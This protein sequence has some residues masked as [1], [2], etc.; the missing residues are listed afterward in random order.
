M[1]SVEDEWVECEKCSKWRRLPNHISADS[2]PDVWE[3]SMT[4]WN[5][6]YSSCTA[7]EEVVKTLED[8]SAL[9]T[10][11]AGTTLKGSARHGGDGPHADGRHH[12]H[13][14][15]DD[16]PAAISTDG[17]RRKDTGSSDDLKKLGLLSKGD[18]REHGLGKGH[19]R[20]HLESDDEKDDAASGVKFDKRKKGR[21]GRGSGVS[22][23]QWVQCDNASCGK[24]R[25]LPPNLKLSD[26]PS[27]WYCKNNTNREFAACTA[28]LEPDHNDRS[29]GDGSSNATGAEAGNKQ[30][31]QGIVER[32][33]KH[34]SH[35]KG[36]NTAGAGSGLSRSGASSDDLKKQSEKMPIGGRP[37]QDPASGAKRGKKKAT[38]SWVQCE[39]CDKWR[40]LPPSVSVDRLP[41]K[42]FCHMNQWDP[43]RASCSAEQELD[44]KEKALADQDYGEPSLPGLWT[45]QKRSLNRSCY[46]DL[47]FNNK[48]K[49][50]NVFDVPDSE[51][52]RVDEHS[53]YQSSASYAPPPHLPNNAVKRAAA[54]KSERKSTGSSS[55]SGK[56]SALHSNPPGALPMSLKLLSHE[57]SRALLFSAATATGAF[58]N[59]PRKTSVKKKILS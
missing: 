40:K 30:P 18:L 7:P 46:R 3:C 14:S 41:E 36:A 33:K 20:K 26:L 32:H 25:S 35:K 10:E 29:G 59:L 27:K 53:F 28:P 5:A 19:K 54:V 49:V 9:K 45:A 58:F 2:I 13:K 57:A 12:R 17:R 23:K 24:W 51:Y 15:E 21:R 6:K 56:H 31:G 55:G 4:T 42:W 44:D 11:K 43:N 8:K 16:S 52:T 1:A 48:G 39:R 37:G 34:A 47:I 50:K 22:N 38:W